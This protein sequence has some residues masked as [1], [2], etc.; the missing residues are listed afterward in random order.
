MA[1]NVMITGAGRSYALGYNMVL[2]YLENGDKVIATVRKSCPD[3]EDLKKKYADDLEILT[4]DIGNTESV[5]LAQKELSTK[6]DHLDLIINNAV[7]VSPDCDKGFF[8]ANLDYIANTINVTSVGAMRVIKAFY[9]MLKKSE[10]TALIINIS[11]EAGS[12]S[13]CYRTNMIDYGMAKAALNMATM[14]LVNTFKD[15]DQIN[16]FCVHPGWIRT[17]GKEDNP[18]PLSSYEAAEILRKLF[19]EKRNEL[20]GPR[21]ITNDGK[22]YPF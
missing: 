6:L 20:T 9:P 21:F 16:I 11:S 13:K 19:E 5:E 8:E 2:R 15:D 17:D 1:Q 4:M 22:E 18:A 12:I 7:T 3:L 14:N 10:D